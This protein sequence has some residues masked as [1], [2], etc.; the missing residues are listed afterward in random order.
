MRAHWHVRK[1]RSGCFNRGAN[2]AAT[3]LPSAQPERYTD[4]TVPNVNAV[5]FVA[6]STSRNQTISSPSAQNPLSAYSISHGRSDPDDPGDGPGM[7]FS[8]VSVNSAPRT[9]RAAATDASR[10]AAAATHVAPVRPPRG[11][12]SHGVANAPPA[13]PRTT[14]S[15]RT[16]GTSGARI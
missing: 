14:S 2:G 3:R 16:P 7:A 10:F 5:D 12:S 4:S 11:T 13:A 1:A 6:T 15:A 8:F 9:A